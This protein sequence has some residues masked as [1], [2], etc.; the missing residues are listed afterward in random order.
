[1]GKLTDS[2]AEQGMQKLEEE[3][4]MTEEEMAGWHATRRR[5]SKSALGVIFYGHGEPWRAAAH[6]VTESW[7]RT[8]RQKLSLD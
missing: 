2:R 4:R 6:R 8:E 1:M 5:K 3:K 7:F